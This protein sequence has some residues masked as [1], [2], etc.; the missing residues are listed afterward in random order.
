M[1][2]FLDSKRPNIWL[3]AASRSSRF[4]S[5]LTAATTAVWRRLGC[6]P[7]TADVVL[8]TRG[9]GFD[10][11]PAMLPSLS[12]T[13]L[14]AAPT[15]HP[16]IPSKQMAWRQSVDNAET[17]S[18]ELSRVD[19]KVVTCC[20]SGY[21]TTRVGARQRRR[22]PRALARRDPESR[23]RGR[24]RPRSGKRPT[25]L[26]QHYDEGRFPG[27]RRESR[28]VSLGC[29]DG[30]LSFSNKETQIGGARGP[31]PGYGR[32]PGI[33]IQKTRKE[34][35]LHA[36]VMSEASTSASQSSKVTACRTSRA[37]W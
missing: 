25:A 9:D 19:Y 22:M 6:L 24:R 11:V 3:H 33:V 36:A 35:L 16:C 13:D 1:N 2:G 5:A 27:L 29:K 15:Q 20:R 17:D 30:L 32:P 7:A 4:A 31:K 26:D 12:S 14:S 37:L 34:L 10:F 23:A 18:P 28:R 8:R 21:A